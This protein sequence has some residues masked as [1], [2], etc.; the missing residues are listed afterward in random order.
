[1]TCS[2][3]TA[4]MF[5]AATLTPDTAA[6][7]L[8][9]SCLHAQNILVRLAPKRRGINVSTRPSQLTPSRVSPPPPLRQVALAALGSWRVCGKVFPTAPSST[10]HGMYVPRVSCILLNQHQPISESLQITR[11]LVYTHAGPTPWRPPSRR[12]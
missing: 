6:C 12:P 1:M 10:Q 5:W 9:E 7:Y 3:G 4:S 8:H 11:A 2:E